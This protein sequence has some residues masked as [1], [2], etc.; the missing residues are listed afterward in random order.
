ML[1]EHAAGF[2]DTILGCV[3]REYPNDLHHRMTGPDD[4]PL[5]HELHPSF[6]GCFD[7]HSAVEMHWALVR[8]LRT[9]PEAVTVVDARAVLNEHLAAAPL[10]TE[11]SYLAEHPLFERP[12]GWGWAAMLVHEVETWDD[13][14]AREWAANLEPLAE[15]LASRY[16]EWL[17]KA[18]YPIRAGTHANSAFSLARAWGFAGARPSLSSAIQDAA[19]RWYGDDADAPAE[20]EP[21][22]YDF[23]SPVLVEAELMSRLLEAAELSRWL[24]G[25]LPALAAEEPATLFTPAVVSDDTDGY[26]GHLHGLNLSR[27]F[28]FKRLAEALP[29]GDRRISVLHGAEQRHAEAALPHVSG[30]DY[31][32]EHWLAAYAVLLLS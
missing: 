23:L 12:Y 5:P 32:L 10:A 11:A 30:G 27:A 18:T 4:R 20:W 19:T 16:V 8:L 26:I 29:A 25:F 9:V 2:A 14:E 13:P 17:A 22:G 21:S 24:D 28:S 15:V 6:Y 1:R 3:A 31:V 7:W